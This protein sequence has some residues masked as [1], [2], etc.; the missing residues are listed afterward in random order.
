MADGCRDLRTVPHVENQDVK[1][2]IMSQSDGLVRKEIERGYQYL[3]AGYV[4][5]QV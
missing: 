4:R 1:S 2:Y 5:L 3:S